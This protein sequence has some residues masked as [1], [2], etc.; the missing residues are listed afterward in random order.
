[1]ATKDRS[2]LKSF[3]KAP[4]PGATAAETQI[5]IGKDQ[6]DETIESAL[7]LQDGG[8]VAGSTTFSGTVNSNGGFT[9]GNIQSAAATDTAFYILNGTRGEIRSQLQTG[10]A[11]D[12]GFTIELRN[13]SIA[14]N[15]LIVANLI[16]GDGALITGSVVTGNVIAADSAS[17]NFF[18]TG[19]AIAD[20]AVFTAS[21]AIL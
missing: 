13:T 9:L 20:N 18:N 11:A 19:I 17:L 14:A 2:T 16:G 8:I 3:F 4:G 10:V 5:K 7:N 6:Y 1:M 15:S 12:T 21:F